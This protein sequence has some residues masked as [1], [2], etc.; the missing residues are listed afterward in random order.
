MTGPE[1]PRI[2][3]YE[4]RATCLQN[5]EDYCE[6]P[7]L[8]EMRA[9]RE[10]IILDLEVLAIQLAKAISAR[11]EHEDD[12]ASMRSWDEV[13]EMEDAALAAFDDACIEID[14]LLERRAEEAAE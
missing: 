11:R 14:E 2:A 10:S 13:R 7:E 12:V 1:V 6:R 3:E 4:R 5:D 9:Q 8:R